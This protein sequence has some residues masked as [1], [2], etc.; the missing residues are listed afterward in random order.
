[1]RNGRTMADGHGVVLIRVDRR[2]RRH[3]QSERASE[4]LSTVVSATCSV[5]SVS[6]SFVHP[7]VRSFGAVLCCA[8]LVAVLLI[9][10]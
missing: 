10:A 7:P 4:C 1:M 8:V 5:S 9:V 6:V 2:R 3:R